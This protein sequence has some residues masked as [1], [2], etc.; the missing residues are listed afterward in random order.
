MVLMEDLPQLLTAA[1]EGSAVHPQL[2]LSL[3]IFP[4]LS[5]VPLATWF[6]HFIHQT[7]L[8]SSNGGV[9]LG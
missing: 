4:V 7:I 9:D 3:R 1:A 5:Y 6:H 2:F 8:L